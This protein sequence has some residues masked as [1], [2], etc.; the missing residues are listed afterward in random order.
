MYQFIK[1]DNCR[2]CAQQAREAQYWM[3]GLAIST[4]TVFV[5]LMRKRA[6]RQN[7]VKLYWFRTL[8]A[9]RRRPQRPSQ[10]ALWTNWWLVDQPTF[11]TLKLL[12]CH[13]SNNKLI[14]DG[15]NGSFADFTLFLDSNVYVVF[16]LIRS[17][18]GSFVRN[19]FLGLQFAERGTAWEFGMVWW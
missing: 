8:P 16:S 14:V 5:A 1:C 17:R 18:Q 9:L 15:I 19:S 13:W 11:V 2:M 10:R 12:F 7:W 6:L 3:R 4:S